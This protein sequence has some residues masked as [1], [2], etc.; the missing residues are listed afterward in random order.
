MAKDI[1]KYR[2]FKEIYIKNYAFK[3]FASLFNSL[4]LE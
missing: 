2:L 1:S 4:K 3:R